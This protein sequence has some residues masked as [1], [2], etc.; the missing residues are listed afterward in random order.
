MSGV[1]GGQDRVPVRTGTADEGGRRSVG[2]RVWGVEG[3]ATSYVEAD[4]EPAP[5][6]LQACGAERRYL[7]MCPRTR[8]ENGAVAVAVRV[9]QRRRAR[10]RAPARAAEEAAKRPSPKLTCLVASD[11]RTKSGQTLSRTVQNRPSDPVLQAKGLC[12]VGK[13]SNM[14]GMS[15]WTAP[16]FHVIL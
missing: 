1:G 14:G 3:L 15:D 9:R 2:A 4:H 13:R 7:C 8:R 12:L 11:A 16:T 6:G 10:A 5:Q